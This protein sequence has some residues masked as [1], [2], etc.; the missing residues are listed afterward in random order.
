MTVLPNFAN[1]TADILNRLAGNQD[2]G[3]TKVTVEQTYP[4]TRI[5]AQGVGAILG[6]SR[7]SRCRR[8][9]L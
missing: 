4:L 7:Q 3:D 1:P 8:S 6:Q 2:S 9:C 5:S